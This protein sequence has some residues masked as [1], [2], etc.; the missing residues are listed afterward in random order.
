MGRTLRFL[1]G[2][3]GVAVFAAV[4][5]NT[6]NS[7]LLDGNGGGGSG[8]MIC[9]WGYCWWSTKTAEGCDDVAAPTAAQKP[10]P[11]TG[12]TDVDVIY[13]GLTKMYIGESLPPTIGPGVVDRTTAPD[14]YQWIGL[15]VDG[16]CT[17]PISCVDAPSDVVPC[18]TPGVQ[19]ADG[20]GCRD[21]MFAKLEP[22]AAVNSQLG[23][24]FGINENDF[25]C[26]LHRGGFNILF[27]ISQ[28]NGTDNDDQVRVDVYASP[29]L[30]DNL[31]GWDCL[32]DK[33]TWDTYAPWLVGQHWYVDRAGLDGDVSQQGALPP[34]KRVYDPAAYV[35]NGY[36]VARIPDGEDLRFI[37][38]RATQRTPL[39]GADPY[40]AAH[41]PGGFS[42]VFRQGIA[43]GH[44]HKNQDSAWVLDDALLAGAISQ[45]DLLAAF[46]KIG[47]C[48]A[49]DGPNWIPDASQYNTLLT[50]LKSN[51]DLLANGTVAPGAACDAMS[52]GIGFTATSIT[53][54]DSLNVSTLHP[55]A[56]PTPAQNP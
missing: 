6:Y 17:N 27:K 40:P 10:K 3:A 42:L 48:A 25:N 36:L 4:A 15:D 30:E 9:A 18:Q 1:L 20:V 44:L 51:M 55:C 43:V 37:G 56:A 34:A 50:Y 7:S 45:D 54:G 52:V 14:P 26:E 19:P 28:Y 23:V 39:K 8:G 31:P 2:G 47:F 46:Q 5:C 11:T 13:L 24:P 29:G 33:T 49:P 41:L 12:T 21:N 38:D 22:V 35:K 16:L 53:P 32:S